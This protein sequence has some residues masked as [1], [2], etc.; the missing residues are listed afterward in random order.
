MTFFFY[1]GVGSTFFTGMYFTWSITTVLTFLST[2]GTKWLSPILT[3]G[4]TFLNIGWKVFGI[5][6]IGIYVLFPSLWTS[7]GPVVFGRIGFVTTLVDGRG[8]TGT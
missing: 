3:T 6:P 5:T 2:I 7:I 8:V 4:V 1:S